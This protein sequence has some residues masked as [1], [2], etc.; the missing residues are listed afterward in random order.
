MSLLLKNA[1]V[2][3]WN[4]STRQ[5]QLE[6]TDLNIQSGKVHF[7]SNAPVAS[8]IDLKGLTVLPGLIDTQVHFREPGLEHKEDL[9]TGTGAAA[10][11]GI[12]AVFEMP[13]TSPPTDTVSALVDK[14]NRA[15]ARV[16]TDVAF[17]AGATTANIHEL[18]SVSKTPGCCGVKVFMGSSTG[19]LLLPNFEDLQELLVRVDCPVAIH[20]ENEFLLRE[21]RDIAESVPASVLNHPLWRNVESAFSATTQ[22]LQAAKAAGRKV[23]I[24]HVS[25]QEE[26][27]LLAKSKAHATCEVT[28]QHLLFNSPD[29]Y[30]QL[31]T[32]AQM[33]PPIREARHRQALW[34]ALQSGHFDMLGSDHAPHLL[35]E[36]A[37][38]YPNSPSGMPGVQTMVP[39]MLN[40]VAE[41]KLSLG[42]LVE[43][44]V[45]NPVRIFKIQNRGAIESGV[46]ATLTIVDLQREETIEKSW[47]ASKCG[48]SPFEGV[49]VKG[50]PVHT[51]LRGQFQMRD[52]ELLPPLGRAL[53]FN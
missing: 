29:C 43:L 46:E 19:S 13:N 7:H 21:R 52:G 2:L 31:G 1:Q 24:L 39:L 17:Y 14:L 12:T 20:A 37:R 5:H 49:K 4:E 34:K 35:S 15:K 32:L 11:G 44:L 25:T 22:A 30:E 50:W 27:E 47:L 53:D 36:K 10:L 48:W 16:H 41:G 9:S 23:H 28:P 3:T 26:I 42:Q 40:C 51:L 18:A 38:V 45:Y 6:V 33:N 8:V